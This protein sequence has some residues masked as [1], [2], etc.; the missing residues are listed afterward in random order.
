MSPRQTNAWRVLLMVVAALA[1]QACTTIP[2]STKERLFLADSVYRSVKLNASSLL[3]RGQISSA[4]AIAYRDRAD[5]AKCGIDTALYSLG[6][7]RQAPQCDL[8]KFGKYLPDVTNPPKTP[9]AWLILVTRVLTDMEN[10][11]KAKGAK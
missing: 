4:Q 1:I 10:E 9:E 8:G 11:L 5:A 2:Q 3:D 7:L 6:E